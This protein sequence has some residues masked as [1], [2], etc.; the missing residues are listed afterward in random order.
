MVNPPSRMIKT[1]QH[2]CCGQTRSQIC[3]SCRITSVADDDPHKVTQQR[4][5][6]STVRS[7]S[8]RRTG[9]A[10][11]STWTIFARVIE[12]DADATALGELHWG[13]AKSACTLLLAIFEI[14]HRRSL[15]ETAGCDCQIEHAGRKPDPADR[16][17]NSV[18]IP[19]DQGA[20]AK[21]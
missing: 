21:T 9:S 20:E 19:P 10:T 12:N 14:N 2:M 17:G 11:T 4:Q 8:R 1:L 18:E 16:L 13:A 3:Q 7:S 15:A 5:S 6:L